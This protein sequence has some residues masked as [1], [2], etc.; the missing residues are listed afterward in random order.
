MKGGLNVSLS[1][2]ESDGN[3]GR[4]NPELVGLVYSSVLSNGPLSLHEVHYI[5]SY[6][7]DTGPKSVFIWDSWL[8]AFFFY[9]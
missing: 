3:Y 1:L 2:S 4:G 8:Q 5:T 7:G 6:L 9:L